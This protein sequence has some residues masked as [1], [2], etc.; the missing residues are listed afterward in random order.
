MRL[1]ELLDGLNVDV[2]GVATI[3]GLEEDFHPSIPRGVFKRAVVIGLRLHD[4]VL[5][6]IKDRPT[7]I[8]KHHYKTVN[9]LLDQTG[10]EVSRRLQRAGFRSLAIAA[11]QL[12]D[13]DARKGALSH[14]E[15][16][17]R[18]GLGFYGKSGLLIHPIHGPRVRYATILTE[19]EVEARE[20]EEIDETCGS[21]TAC[22]RACPAEAISEDGI[23]I[24]KCRSKLGEFAS[25]QGIGQKI[26]GVC[27]ASRVK[28]QPC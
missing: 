4:G 7:L 10:F 20:P 12:V 18:A 13:W 16:G 9:W 25:I 1:E 8:Y 24:G 19:G 23:D 6:G 14:R 15:M 2:S 28:S 27:V 5:Q 11:S 22:I 21:C 17:V 3:E 26:C